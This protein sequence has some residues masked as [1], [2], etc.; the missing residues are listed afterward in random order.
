MRERV[1]SFRLLN[2]LGEGG[3][4]VVYAAQD[5]RLGRRVA[6]KMIRET[7]AASSA[8]ERFWREATCW[9]RPTR[10]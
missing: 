9:R 3:M 10:R 8:R 7:S 5:E 1:G 4:G 6:I 2:R